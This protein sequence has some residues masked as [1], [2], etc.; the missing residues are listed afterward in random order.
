MDL[1]AE[2]ECRQ[3]LEP[4]KAHYML[5]GFTQ[6]RGVDYDGIFS[7][8]VKPAIVRAVM[9][10]AL[11]RDWPIHQLDVKNASSM[12]PCRRRSIALSPLGLSTPLT[13]TWSASSTSPSTA[14]S[15]PPGLGTVASPPS[16]VHGA[17]SRPSRTRPCS[18]SV[19]VRTL[20]TSSSTSTTSCSPPPPL[21]SCVASSP[22]SSRTLR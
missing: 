16:C 21:G 12:A 17:S 20:H 8:V 7:P 11:S 9:T 19:V 2:A 13:P 1:Q 18:S 15:R 5:R 3:V 14:S 6:R 10:L 22:A 4:Y